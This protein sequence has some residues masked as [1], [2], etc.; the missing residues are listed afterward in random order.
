MLR[1]FYAEHIDRA[2]DSF[3]LDRTQSAHVKLALRLREGDL[4]SAFDGKGSEFE[5][6]IAVLNKKET[7]LK[8]VRETDPPASESS[9]KLTL[10]AALLKND[11]FELVIQKATELGVTRLVPLITYRTEKVLK[12]AADRILRWRRIVIES[13]K[14]CG[15]ATLMEITEPSDFNEAVEK[16]EGQRVLFGEKDGGALEEIQT[17]NEVVAFIGPEGGWEDTEISMAKENGCQIVTIGS[18][19]LRAETA[20]IAVASLLQHRFGDL[21]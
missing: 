21:S 7:R 11:K 18:R 17:S 14:Q 2:A 16:L 6:E 19:V 8:I 12:N 1:R 3:P 9:L 10:A 4:V 20:S 15:R 13:S 5:C